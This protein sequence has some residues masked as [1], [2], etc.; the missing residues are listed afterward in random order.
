MLTESDELPEGAEVAVV[1]ADAP[2][3]VR[4]TDEELA[5]IDAGLAAAERSE[6]V[7]ARS[8]LRQLRG[9]MPEL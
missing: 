5:L 6:R 9:T 1:V 8:F 3:F 4:A 7:D 2:G